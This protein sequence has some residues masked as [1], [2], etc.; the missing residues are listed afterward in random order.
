MTVAYRVR[1]SEDRRKIFYRNARTRHVLLC[2]EAANSQ[3]EI[4][5]ARVPGGR[6]RFLVRADF[7]KSFAHV[8][9][10]SVYT[11]QPYLGTF[12]QTIIIIA[13]S[14]VRVRCVLA[15][16]S[17][18]YINE[19]SRERVSLSLY[20]VDRVATGLQV[21]GTRRICAARDTRKKQVTRIII[22]IKS[23]PVRSCNCTRSR[24]HR[25]WIGS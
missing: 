12:A 4:R 7:A 15:A 3:D 20:S 18:R 24:V 16:P 21:R 8:C 25:L 2:D 17:G 10:L 23:P 6:R 11:K 5:E 22:E 9:A 19:S 13:A 1:R 14:R